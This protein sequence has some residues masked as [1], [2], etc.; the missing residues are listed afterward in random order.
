MSL[1]AAVLTLSDACSR[2]ERADGSGPL[3]AE[4]LAASGFAVGA[5]EILPDE[6]DQIAARLRALAAEFDLIATT[7]G[8]GFGPRD[9]TPEATLAAAERLAP[10]LAE[11]MRAAGA[12]STPQAW[13]SRAAAAIRG[14]CLILNLPGSPRGA[15]ESLEAVLPLLPHALRLLRGEKEH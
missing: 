9:V 10:G 5:V 8:T 15:R 1:R 11:A 6:R 4:L 3:V 2:G 14:G 7:G 12:R 13:L